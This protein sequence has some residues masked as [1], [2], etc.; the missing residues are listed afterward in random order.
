MKAFNDVVPFLLCKLT[1]CFPSLQI[2]EHTL[3]RLIIILLHAI[4]R[5]LFFVLECLSPILL[6]LTQISLP[7]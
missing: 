1:Y 5:A 6:V 4:S 3:C 2:P 7:L